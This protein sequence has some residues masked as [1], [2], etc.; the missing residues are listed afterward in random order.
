MT[1]KEAK[2]VN[3]IAEGKST[4]DAAIAAGYKGKKET[5]R[6]NAYKMLKNPRIRKALDEALDEAGATIDKSAKVIAEAHKAND[7]EF[8]NKPD[9]PV[10]L[11]AAEM[12]LR[13]RR[14]IGTAEGNISQVNIFGEAFLERLIDAYQAR[15]NPPQ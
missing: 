6:V 14:L 12:N 9:H 13:A 5:L 10:R 7:N 3:G 1:P 2:L 15:N 11:K 8:I 4:L